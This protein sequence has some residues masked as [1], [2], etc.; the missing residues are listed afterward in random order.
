[1]RKE[2][3]DATD[4]DRCTYFNFS[5]HTTPVVVVVLHSKRVIIMIAVVV[6]GPQTCI[7]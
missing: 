5:E 2:S 4:D 6:L 7:K 1:M 3:Y